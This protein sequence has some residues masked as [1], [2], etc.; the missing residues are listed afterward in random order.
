MKKQMWLIYIVAFMCVA[1]YTA[2]LP[3]MPAFV[4]AKGGGISEIGLVL[5]LVALIS[6][7]TAPIVGYYGD[8]LGRRPVLI[9]SMFGFGI[10]YGLFALAP[11]MPLVYL[12]A[13]IGGLFVAGAMSVA[14][15]YAADTAGGEK[16][17][18]VIAKMQA[19]QMVGALLPPLAAGY[20]AEININLPFVALAAIAI[21][22][23]V[24][25]IFLLGESLP[26]EVVAEGRKSQMSPVAATA[27]SFAKIFSYLKTP[28]GPLL[29]IALMIAFPTGFFQVALPLLTGK[30]GLSTGE[31]GLIFSMGTLSIVLVNILLV[32]WLM[33]KIGYW[34]NILIGMIAAVI[35]YIA[36]PF[37][38]SFWAFM[39]INLLLS[40]TTSSM[41]PAQITLIARQVEATEQS[42]AQSAYNQWTAIGNIFGPPL[43]TAL[44]SAFNG[45][46]TMGVAAALF[47][48]GAGYAF[49]TSRKAQQIASE[50]ISE[51]ASPH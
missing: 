7:V 43:G 41:R 36:L 34:A 26:P 51:P 50:K 49:N 14:T 21:V 1:G 12:G 48:I 46:V 33:K 47:L 45:F 20:L 8:R 24:L 22:T 29:V 40:I 19:A 39:I 17:G 4:K 28:I 2:A 3:V 30:A 27:K 32:E 16:T 42:V 18:G 5:G 38:G 6:V 35:F 10:W 9:A 37:C 23:A 44:Y 13:F 15:A 11:S 31:T 25:M